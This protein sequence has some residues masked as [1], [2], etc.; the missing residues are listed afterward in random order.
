MTARALLATDPRPAASDPIALAEALSRRFAATAAAHDRDASV[1]A[2]NFAALAEAGLLALTVPRA[3]GGLGAGLVTATQVL[4]RIGRGEPS[5]ALI[6]AMH[7]INHATNIRT[8]PEPIRARL[9]RETLDGVALVNALRVE[10]ELGTPARGG[11][12]ATVARRTEAGWSIRG[13]KIYSTGIPVLRWLMVWGRT[14]ELAPRTGVFLVPG[15]TPGIRVVPSWNHLGMRATASHDVVLEDVAIPFENAV[16]L[17]PPEAWR[18]PD[19]E[20]WAWA[21]LGVASLYHGVAKAARDWLL[22]FLRRRAPSNLGAPLAT[23]PRVQEQVGE[24]EALLL[25]SDRLLASGAHDVEAGRPPRIEES[26]LIKSLVTGNAIA[27]VEA[28]VRLA[29]NHA[30]SRDNPLERHYRDV[31]CGRIHTPQDDSV[32]LAAGRAALEL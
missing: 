13:H 17:R 21:T 12:P 2:E 22:D 27:A 20:Y 5:T 4:E 30:L 31:L 28:A 7:Y 16:D 14:D 1:P 24:I 9:Q 26:G 3:A 25:A 18:A 11:L 15:D 6:L 32:R 23:L 29:G 8:W 10:P 19:P